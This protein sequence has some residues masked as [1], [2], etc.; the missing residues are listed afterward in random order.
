MNIIKLNNIY[1]FY[2]TGKVI[3]KAINGISLEISNNEFVAI[4]GPLYSGKTTL[5]NIIGCLDV[6]T[7]GEYFLNHK[8]VSILNDNQFAQIR[9]KEIGFV[10][11]SF[12]LM[13]R[14]TVL[15]NVTLPLVYTG[16]SLKE[17]K[18]KAIE[19]LE[20]VNIA[21]KDLNKP[22]KLSGGEFQRVAIARSLVNNPSIILANEP[23]RKFKF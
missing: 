10:F 5:M 7:A 4:M 15:E 9:N 22:N 18:F 12:N 13:P 3:V 21:S 19:V 23:P 6:P 14:Y 17:E 8:K 20:K 1:K 16:I 11:Q 2:K